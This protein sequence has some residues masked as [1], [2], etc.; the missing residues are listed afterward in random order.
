MKN[1]M[2]KGKEEKK[3]SEVSQ[4]AKMHVLKAISEKAG[5][6]MGDTLSKKVVV[7]ADTTEGL[8]KG[9]EVAE[10]K[11]DEVSEEEMGEIEEEAQ[12]DNEEVDDIESEIEEL[13]KQLEELK[14]QR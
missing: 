4:E 14:S 6:D 1:L 10:D 9:L 8:K 2:K 7:K 11:L 5:S 3:L 12:E 13:E